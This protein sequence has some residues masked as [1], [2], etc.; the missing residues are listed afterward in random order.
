MEIK[1]KNLLYL[2]KQGAVLELNFQHV[3]NRKKESEH[4]QVKVQNGSSALSY[5]IESL[6]EIR[7]LAEA[8][9]KLLREE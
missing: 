7:A 9:N 3:K 2:A 4:L 5:E 1:H 6:A 8:L